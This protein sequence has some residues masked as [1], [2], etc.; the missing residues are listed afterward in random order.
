MPGAHPAS[1]TSRTFPPSTKISVP[2]TESFSRVTKRNRETLAI[3]GTASPRK[4]RVMIV[5]KSPTVRNLL[6]AW[7]SRDRSASSRDIPHP[8]SLTRINAAPPR[9]MSTRISRAPASMLFS[10][11]SLTTEAGRSTTSPAATWLARISGSTRIFGIDPAM[12]FTPQRSAIPL[13]Q[14]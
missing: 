8:S 1:R 7:R 5:A 6:V 4:P 9:S 13:T 12:L 3:L 14:G 2:A 11:S 10:T